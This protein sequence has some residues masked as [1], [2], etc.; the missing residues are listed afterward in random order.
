MHL[1]EL[2]YFQ[3]KAWL[4]LGEEL[5]AQSVVTDMYREWQTLIRVR[6]NGFFQITPFFISSTDDPEKCRREQ[7]AYLMALCYDAMGMTERASAS[8]RE[9]TA[10]SDE[11]LLALTFREQ[12]FLD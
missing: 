2:P 9:A 4:H 11:N 5:K 3:A 8:L 12:G 10:A 6:D 7:Y 1:K